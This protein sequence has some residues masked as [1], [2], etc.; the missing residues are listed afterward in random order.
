[1]A[2]LCLGTEISVGTVNNVILNIIVERVYQHRC[3]RHQE[4]E[5][6]R[7]LGRYHDNAIQCLTITWG[8]NALIDILSGV[9]LEY[10]FRLKST[11]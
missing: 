4:A 1:M 7:G 2:I 3:V 8:T 10:T 6:K 5:R 9:S 11:Y